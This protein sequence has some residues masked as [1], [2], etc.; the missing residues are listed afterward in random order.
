MQVDELGVICFKM[1][2]D[3]TRLSFAIWNQ[4]TVYAWFIL[5]DW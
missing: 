1:D 4:V 2:S 5:E 3:V